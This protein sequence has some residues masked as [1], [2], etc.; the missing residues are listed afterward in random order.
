[1]S[2]AAAAAGDA[3]P[4]VEAAAAAVEEA[5][6]PAEATAAH[7][8]AAKIIEQVEF[9]FGDSNLMKPDKFMVSKITEN[10][11]GWVELKIIASFKRMK[12]LLEDAE[13][14]VLAATL[15]TSENDLLE[16][17]DDGLTVRRSPTRPLPKESQFTKRALYTKGWDLKETTI[18][19]V[20]AY[21]VDKGYEVVSV[22][23]RSAPHTKEF[24]GS[25]FVEMADVATAQKAVGEE[26]PIG[27]DR[28]L[29]IE[30]KE[31]YHLRKK[32]ER[33]D[34]SKSKRK[35]S[36][37]GA[38][39]AK[40]AKKDGDKGDA[41]KEEPKDE[42]FEAGLILQFSGLTEETKREDI[43]EGLA[44]YGEVGWVDFQIGDT[45]GSLRLKEGESASKVKE[46]ADADALEINGAK[47]VLTVLEGDE[48]RKSVV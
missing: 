1:M 35:G 45:D 38:E 36:E 21:F 40:K 13:I 9:Y 16:V 6:A 37:G 20:K 27:E 23:L 11:E 19:S 41:V 26:H 22:R 5:A 44:K 34:K 15:K 14:A 17:S 12:T 29:L 46:Q 10:P 7:A 39:G 30:M 24:K 3:K 48:D 8:N 47:V 4:A 42:P 32:A 28:K 33:T 25:V 18:D 43:K 2:D 31:A